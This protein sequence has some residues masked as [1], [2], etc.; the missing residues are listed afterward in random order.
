MRP[1]TRSRSRSPAAQPLSPEER[2]ARTVFIMQLSQRVRARDVE[3][4]FSAVGKIRDVKLII[5]NKTRRF[6][7][8]AY[9]EFKDIE[10]VPLVR[11][12]HDL[13]M[14]SR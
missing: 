2:D 1:A 11:Q 10:S 12:S 14:S 13:P 9:V 5:C 8:I 7:G 4:F 3:E 6:K